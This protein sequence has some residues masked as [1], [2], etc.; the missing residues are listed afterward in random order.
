MNTDA[1]VSVQPYSLAA[2]LNPQW[3][4][5]DLQ[6]HLGGVPLSRIRLWPPPGAASEED[7]SRNPDHCELIDGVLVEK[8]MGYFQGWIAAELIYF[9]SK[10]VREH[11]LGIVLG[12]NSPYR[13]QPKSIREP[14]ISYFG[15]ARFPG[16]V[17]PAVNVLPF[18]PDLAVEIVS[19][20]NTAAEMERKRQE[21]FAAGT[22]AFWVVEPVLRTI[23]VSTTYAAP[24]LLREGDTL[25]GG[26][27][28]PGFVLPLTELFARCPRPISE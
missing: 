13:L 12:D 3:S 9:L 25:I 4:L 28:L 21:F 10:F 5:Q 1:S 11:D 17:P 7:F 26:E 24:Q 19:D 22:H 6:T 14:D 18:A 23:E 2:P 15:W 8:A 27:V 20:G 16:R